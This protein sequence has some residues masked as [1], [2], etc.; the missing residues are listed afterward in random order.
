[1]IDKMINKALQN[2]DFINPQV[3]LIR[4]NENM[5]YKVMDEN[6]SYVFRIHEPTEGFNVDLIKADIVKEELIA[7][8]MEVLDYLAD[9]IL[10]QK[11]KLN[12]SG[13][14]VSLLNDGKLVTILNW[15]DG[16]TLEFIDMTSEIAFLLGKMI[17]RLHNALSKAPNKQRYHY[18]DKLISRMMTEA[19]Y[20]FKQGYFTEHQANLINDT[21]SII[22]DYLSK[23]S[24]RFILVHSDLSK[25]NLIYHNEMLTP[26]DFSL[27][28]YCVPEM[29]LASA[30]SHINDEVLNVEILKGYKTMCNNEI[31]EAGIDICFCLQILLFVVCQYDKFAHE[32]WFKEKI[33]EW[34]EKYFS[35]L[36]QLR[37]M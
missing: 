24:N 34:G 14:P 37:S 33:D 1:M 29:D 13:E 2:Y 26:I 20:A 21:L 4:H 5:T 32:D 12:I 36:I 15:I 27:S 16:T 30:F 9:T 10:V 7:G 22:K 23:T 19:S 18:D 17:G 35:P 28:G 6:K 25:S 8:E 3:E 11:P 31:D